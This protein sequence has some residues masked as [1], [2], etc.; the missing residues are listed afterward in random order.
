MFGSDFLESEQLE[1]KN[2][3][4]NTSY[5]IK[6]IE[7]QYQNEKQNRDEGEK[8]DIYTV[9]LPFIYFTTSIILST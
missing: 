4:Y 2:L 7:K 6:L 9:I 3:K 5:D 1:S 8:Y